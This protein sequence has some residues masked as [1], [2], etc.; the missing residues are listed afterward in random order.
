[1]FIFFFCS[2]TKKTKMSNVQLLSLLFFILS[3][4]YSINGE[5]CN[6]IDYGYS[7]EPIGVCSGYAD[8]SQ[9]SNS[10]GICNCSK[11][12]SHV[13]CTSYSST[14]DCTGTIEYSS[15]ITKSD[16]AWANFSCNANHDCS[17]SYIKYTYPRSTCTGSK[18]IVETYGI[19]AGVCYQTDI[20]SSAIFGCDNG[21]MTSYNYSDA[22]CTVPDQKDT[23]L[24]SKCLL[25]DFNKSTVKT[26]L[27][28]G[29]PG[30][31]GNYSF[32]GFKSSRGSRS[33]IS[34]LSFVLITIIF[35]FL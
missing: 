16:K 27:T 10:S 13:V 20:N 6:Y 11:D 18:N 28:C 15:N 9:N 17:F 14:F 25:E 29:S 30:Y 33:Q 24:A 3:T 19:V 8:L 7:Y 23:T 31:F 26:L 21:V 12:G 34:F 22:H 2:R 5:Y 35:K 32:E 1:V 4:F